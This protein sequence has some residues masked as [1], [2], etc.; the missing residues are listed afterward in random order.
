MSLSSTA[1]ESSVRSLSRTNRAQSEEAVETF[2]PPRFFFTG[3][4]G[5]IYVDRLDI[6]VFI[7][8]PATVAGVWAFQPGL[9]TQVVTD[10]YSTLSSG[11]VLHAEE[12]CHQ[13]LAQVGVPPPYPTAT[14]VAFIV[15]GMA[16]CSISY[17]VSIGRKHWALRDDI[18]SQLNN[19]RERVRELE[20]RVQAA[21]ILRREKLK[22]KGEIR[23]FMEGA[24]DLMHYGHMNAFRLGQSLGTQ[25]VVGVNSS[26]TI[27]EC[28]GFAP[29]MND[30]ERCT[31][32]LGCRFVDEV[33]RRT[34]YVM[35]EEYLNHIV[36]TYNIDYVV[37]GDDPCIVNGKDVYGHV[38]AMGKYRSI[39]RTEGVSTT[40]IVGRMLLCGTSHHV[41]GGDESPQKMSKAMERFKDSDWKSSKFLTTSNV[42]RAFSAGMKTPPEG[43]R[44]VYMDGAWDMF[45]AGHVDILKKAQA[46]GDYLIVGVFSDDLVNE[47]RG[48]NF[49]IMNLNERV[50]SVMGCKHVNDVLIDCPWEISHDMISSLNITVVAHG[51][52]HD[53][54]SQD[55][56]SND[57]EVPKGLGIYKTIS[58]DR[59]LGV[60]EII[61]RINRSRERYEKK[62]I[63]KKEAEDEYYANRYG[64]NATPP[65]SP[66]RKAK[67][68]AR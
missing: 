60:H 57:Y 24:F 2:T 25:L 30:D 28:K 41:H 44:V 53:G 14:Q 38:K 56:P 46:L 13:K 43:A 59:D 49:P 26:E 29:V 19:A 68:K 65:T 63:K 52:A 23:I 51:T 31:A 21:D 8:L 3:G 15:F 32:V 67:K 54:N 10:L 18:T 17:F 9:T 22:K 20:D 4:L 40:D 35:T 1:S 12:Y 61:R 62:F 66:N 11:S 48:S 7:L 37:H 34:P 36:D 58:S 64:R 6:A 45:H 50:L 33:V 39:P 5:Y 42:L 27:A 16:L 47:Y 55:K